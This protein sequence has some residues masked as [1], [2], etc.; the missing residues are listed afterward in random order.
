MTSVE[1]SNEARNEMKVMVLTDL[2]AL[3]KKLSDN[4]AITNEMRAEARQFLA[5]Y[6]LIAPFRGK[7]NAAQHIEGELLID[8]I[9]RFIPRVLEIESHPENKPDDQP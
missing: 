5:D 1:T 9:A 4:P 7:G 2:A 6:N 8:Q 3:C